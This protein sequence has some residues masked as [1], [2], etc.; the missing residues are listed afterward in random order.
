MCVNSLPI[1]L[2]VW[3]IHQNIFP[4]SKNSLN[5]YMTY[6]DHESPLLINSD[7]YT[8]DINAQLM[9]RVSE[10]IFSHFSSVELR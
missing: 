7:S 9:T 4:A 8:V 6:F 5:L 1:Y 3:L 10:H 2:S